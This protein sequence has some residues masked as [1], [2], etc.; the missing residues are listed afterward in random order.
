MDLTCYDVKFTIT[1]SIHGEIMDIDDDHD[2]FDVDDEDIPVVILV[3]TNDESIYTY[4]YFVI[5]YS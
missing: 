5:L 4:Q 3:W 2:N 1:D